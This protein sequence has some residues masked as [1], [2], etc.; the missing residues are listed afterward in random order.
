MLHGLLAHQY[1][2]HVLGQDACLRHQM[3]QLAL[4]DPAMTANEPCDSVL[5]EL[6]VIEG[7]GH[8][9]HH[10]AHADRVYHHGPCGHN[11]GI[12]RAH[13]DWDADG[14]AASQHQGDSGLAQRGNHLRDGK[15]RLHVP[16]HGVQ[17]HQNPLYVLAVLDCREAW[18]NMLIFR[19][20]GIIGKVFMPL[21]FSDDGYEMDVPQFPTLVQGGLSGLLYPLVSVLFFFYLLVL[22]LIAHVSL[23]SKI[24]CRSYFHSRHKFVL[25]PP[26]VPF[27]GKKIPVSMEMGLISFL[28]VLLYVSAVS[29]RSPH[30]QMSKSSSSATEKSKSSSSAVDFNP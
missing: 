3:L 2:T 22:F 9:D 18:Q 24:C 26:S 19:G 23:L 29:T 5:Y 16:A 21:N 28:H 6:E 12:V 8:A 14:M 30:C 20:L 11:E 13:G 15:A 4:V 10:A 7:L 27:S 1:G 17:Q 25:H